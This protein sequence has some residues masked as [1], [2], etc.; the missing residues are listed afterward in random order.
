MNGP[1]AQAIAVLRD[2]IEKGVGLDR[3]FES[4]GIRVLSGRDQRFCRELV[5]GVFRN[6]SLLDYL[7]SKCSRRRLD[8]IDRIVLWILRV[9][10]YQVEFLR[11]PDYASVHEAGILCRQ[12]RKSSA[13]A[14]VNGILR[15]YLRK[16][17]ALPGDS[18]PNSLAIRYSHPEWLVKRYVTRYGLA[19]TEAI[20]RLN[21]ETP[22]PILW[23]NP[24]KTSLDRF[25]RQLAQEGI[26][27]E[28]LSDLPNAVRLDAT[29]FTEH[30]LY[31]Q[32]H[33][34][35]MDAASQ[36]IARLVDLSKGRLIG[37][38]CAAP[39]GKSFLMAE[40]LRRKGRIFC[41]DVSFERLSQ[42]RTRAEQYAIPGLLFTQMDLTRKAA[43]ACRFDALLLDV[44]CSG[45]GTLRS[46][47]DA[48]W[49][50]EES[51]LKSNQKRQ[52]SILH[53]AFPLLRT[54]KE[55]IYST[56]S[57][58]PEENEE[59]VERFLRSEPSSHLCDEYFRTL[60]HQDR[61]EGF[62]AARVRRV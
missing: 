25:Q 56:C 35:F 54:G 58:E 27:C 45:T 17:P 15:S 26:G 18:S 60:P 47:P 2:R 31:R 37:D 49:R 13:H 62:F 61:G 42:A 14:F 19:Q 43:C 40:R 55:L 21:N 48:R 16:T 3:L 46:N 57:T 36:R 33:C 51:D 11:V 32:G 44:P 41:S 12:F 39:G 4:S 59:V 1:R 5:Y 7:I 23:V 53:N 20:L 24:F 38:L 29:G 30:E 28:L 9:S 52:L 10:I 8:K 22:E 50:L 34:F 6:L